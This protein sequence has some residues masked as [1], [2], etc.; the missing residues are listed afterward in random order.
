MKTKISIIFAVL[1]LTLT[2]CLENEIVKDSENMNFRDAEFAVPLAT[3][4]IPL[5]RL[6]EEQLFDEFEDENISFTF[7]GNVLTAV[8]KFKHEVDVKGNEI[9]L[10][11]VSRKV[12][13]DFGIEDWKNDIITLPEGVRMVLDEV[14][15][16]PFNF[17]AP[18]TIDDARGNI[19]IE[20]ATFSKG[21]LEITLSE[22]NPDVLETFEFILEIPKL[23]K[24]GVSFRTTITQAQRGQGTQYE[25][26]YGYK[27]ETE[28]IIESG[29]PDK[30]VVEANVSFGATAI[31]TSNITPQ[32]E[33]EIELAIN[34]SEVYELFG[35]FG[36]IDINEPIEESI[37]G[38]F[39]SLEGFTNSFSV[40]GVTLDIDVINRTGIPLKIDEVEVFFANEAYDPDNNPSSTKPLTIFEEMY[41][42]AA[43]FEV[44]YPPVQSRKGDPFTAE[45]DFNYQRLL[46]NFTGETNF[47]NDPDDPNFV[48]NFIRNTLDDNNEPVPYAELEITLSVPFHFDMEEPYERDDTL[49]FNYRNIVFDDITFSKSVEEFILHLNV[50]KYD[51]PLSYVDLEI[52]A[53]H[54]EGSPEVGIATIKLDGRGP[55]EIKFGQSVLSKLW[56]EDVQHLILRTITSIDDRAI[57]RNS[58][59]EIK[60]GISFKSNLPI[61]NFL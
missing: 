56:D 15:A 26:L 59:L 6:I 55:K 18:I 54:S 44:V 14:D 30:Y 46:I 23:K 8:Y 17:E 9:G 50:T 41:I 7:N 16:E 34:D 21:L 2:A 35:Y 5:A 51:L 12:E 10:D 11:D 48:S 29:V 45:F 4:N 13:Y 61:N 33:F 1:M 49:G 28:R 3:I 36:V 27:L 60:V 57:T 53:I 31:V 20:S 52:V 37:E 43:A 25:D 19:F 38:L 58:E 42:E 47:G 39:N 22:T 24:D 40:L 32:G